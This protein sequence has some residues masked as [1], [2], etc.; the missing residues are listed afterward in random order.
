[1]KAGILYGEVSVSAPLDEQDVL[2]QVDTVSRALSELGYTPI[3]IPFSLQI[4]DVIK[5]L[6]E[7]RPAFVFNLVESVAGWGNLIHLAPSI[8]DVLHIPYTGARTEA[9][10]LTSHKIVAK[11]FLLGKGIATPP[12]FLPDSDHTFP[13][14]SGLYI[15]KSVWEHASIW[16][17]DDSIIFSENQQ[18]LCQMIRL[19]QERIGTSCFAER[20]IEGREFNISLLGGRE[21]LTILPPAEIVFDT[22]PPG[23][24]RVVDFR[25]K[26]V[27]DSF[28]Y[29]NTP[30]RFTFPD[31]DSPLLSRLKDIS[32]TCWSVFNLRGYARVD[33]RVDESGQPWVLEINT[34]PC[35][36]PNGGFY[37]A[38]ERAGLSFNEAIERIIQ[39]AE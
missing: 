34:N 28:E 3:R 19:R 26:W 22:Y 12:F 9:T 15:I 31:E 38:V 36:S 18:H 27:E 13:F 25:A 16:L 29:H 1:M 7:I 24:R 30:R 10:F 11:E 17:D 23:K 39:D 4:G 2:V 5:A 32:R 6:Q 8:L 37:A 20:F 35:L 21:G 14:S 33:F